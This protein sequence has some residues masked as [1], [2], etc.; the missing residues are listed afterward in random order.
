[1]EAAACRISP[2]DNIHGRSHVFQ[3]AVLW[4]TCLRTDLLVR[5]TGEKTQG[6]NEHEGESVFDNR[7]AKAISSKLLSDS[8]KLICEDL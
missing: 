4:N 2:G 6:G 7:W 3:T 8:G 1:M 5:K